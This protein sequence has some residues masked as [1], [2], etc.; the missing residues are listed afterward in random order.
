MGCVGLQRRRGGC[1]GASGAGGA[2]CAMQ[3]R[4]RGS[5][6]GLCCR[7]TSYALRFS[8]VLQRIH[9]GCRLGSCLPRWAKYTPSGGT[10]PTSRNKGRQYF[11][12][13]PLKYKM[14]DPTPMSGQARAAC[15]NPMQRLGQLSVIAPKTYNTTGTKQDQRCMRKRARS[16]AQPP[17][18]SPELCGEERPPLLISCATTVGIHATSPNPSAPHQSHEPHPLSNGISL[19]VALA[20]AN[21]REGARP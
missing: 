17:C 12:N 18:T 19:S 10:E 16:C 13:R 1:V 15:Y 4:C 9:R 11:R 20:V 8:S 7:H 3:R 6:G 2:G 5:P 21:L 14:W